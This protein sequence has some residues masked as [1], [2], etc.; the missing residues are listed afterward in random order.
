MQEEGENAGIS[1]ENGR[2]VNRGAFPCTLVRLDTQT[3]P[4]RKDP[5]H[6]ISG[7]LHTYPPG[8]CG[9]GS[10]RQGSETTIDGGVG[11]GSDERACRDA[12]RLRRCRVK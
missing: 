8:K 9:R 3:I 1:G 6:Q 4:A 7:P 11:K 2:R 12:E 5:V 10:S